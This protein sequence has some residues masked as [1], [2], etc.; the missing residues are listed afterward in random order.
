LIASKQSQDSD[1]VNAVSRTEIER[2]PGLLKNGTRVVV[3]DFGCKNNIL[4]ILQQRSEEVIVVPSR[5]SAEEVLS[6]GPS[7]VMLSNG[8]G[9]PAE[10]LVAPE[11]IKK[12]IGRVPIFAICMGH[13]L[14][15]RVLGGETYKLKFGHRAS[16]HPVRDQLLNLVYV[17]AQNH[18]YAVRHLPSSV[19]VT[20]TNLNDGSCAG[21]FSRP[22]RI[23]SVQFHPEA[24]PGP[25]EGRQLFEY[26][27][28]QFG[29]G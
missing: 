16:N 11:T 3:L 23:L 20:H 10:V 22:L 8:P 2:L 26:F 9:D 6:F 5:T 25:H 27:Y 18:G 13:Q 24:A 21:F 19:E 14:L 7:F 1:W 29:L 15:A 17:T 4:R 28:K 12:L